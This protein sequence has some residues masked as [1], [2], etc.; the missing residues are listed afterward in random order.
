MKPVFFLLVILIKPEALAALCGTL[1]D[2][3]TQNWEHLFVSSSVDTTVWNYRT[4]RKA[5]SAQLAANVG[6]TNGNLVISLKK[7]Q[8][9][10]YS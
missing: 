2:L 9:G 1:C 3:Y 8:V 7:Q 10:A 4:D 5:L 6:Q